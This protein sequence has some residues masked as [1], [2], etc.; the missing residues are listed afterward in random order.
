M[1]VPRDVIGKKRKTQRGFKGS[2]NS[3]KSWWKSH[4]RI[5]RGRLH[6]L[7]DMQCWFSSELLGVG[8]I[9]SRKAYDIES[10]TEHFLSP[11]VSPGGL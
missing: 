5:S 6:P 10:E 9:L 4:P 7:A 2:F 8:M 11:F 3:Y 1:S